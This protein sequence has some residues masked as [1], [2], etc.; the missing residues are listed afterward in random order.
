M[1]ERGGGGAQPLGGKAVTLQFYAHAPGSLRRRLTPT[2]PG[3]PPSRH[4][5]IKP[6]FF[7]AAAQALLPLPSG[8]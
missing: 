3:W 7:F 2:A 4:V 1:L 6:P 5:G 8:W